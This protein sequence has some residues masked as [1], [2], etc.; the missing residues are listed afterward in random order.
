MKTSPSHPSGRLI[1]SS[2]SL[3]PRD[4]FFFLTNLRNGWVNSTLL[5][6]NISQVRT[7]ASKLIVKFYGGNMMGRALNVVNSSSPL[8]Q[9]LIAC[10]TARLGLGPQVYGCDGKGR[11]EE[12]I[13]CD[14]L[15]HED[16]L[17]S[18]V[19]VAFARFH[20]IKLPLCRDRC[21]GRDKG[22]F[23]LM[24]HTYHDLLRIAKSKGYPSDLINTLIAEVTW[25]EKV[26]VTIGIENRT[27]LVT[28]DPNYMNRLVVK[29]T[30][31]NEQS[32]IKLI[33]YDCTCHSWRG[34][35]L[36]GHF[37]CQMFDFTDFDNICTS[38]TYPDEKVQI[39]F[40]N[41]YLSEWKH[42]NP[43]I[44]DEKVDSLPNLLGECD[45]G[46]MFM[47]LLW[48]WFKYCL[49]QNIEQADESVFIEEPKTFTRYK[50]MKQNFIKK[51]S[52]S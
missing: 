20:S 6:K 49:M 47:C 37:V 28:G 8:E 4:V 50:E 33:D 21:L 3:L 19:A 38:F 52:L 42:L 12:F 51:Y 18:D 23:C 7:Q 5:V 36:G 13:E 46:A 10:E 15:T 34:I 30:K 29:D 26:N 27:V 32:K 9:A 44:F 25:L 24:T 39:S 22:D 2:H 17:R 14:T 48:T 45:I 31:C 40:L 43:E 35:E 41:T 1:V 11:I 16:A